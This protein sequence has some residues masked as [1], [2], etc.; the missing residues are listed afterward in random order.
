LEE[1]AIVSLESFFAKLQKSNEINDLL[2][3]NL[4]I[5]FAVVTFL[6]IPAPNSLL[7]LR[8]HSNNT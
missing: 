4:F 2:G 5:F 1:I 7:S 8:G 6:D 3:K